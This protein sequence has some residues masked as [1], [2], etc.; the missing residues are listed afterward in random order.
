VEDRRE[1]DALD[2]RVPVDFPPVGFCGG[3]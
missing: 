2:E 3:K 1:V